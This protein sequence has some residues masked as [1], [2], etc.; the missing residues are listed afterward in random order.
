MT[1]QFVDLNG[2]GQQDMVTATFE[3]TAFLVEGSSEGWKEPQHIKDGKDSNVRISMYYDMEENEYKNVDRSS[4]D[5]KNIEEHHMTSLALVDWDE[6]GDQDLILGA[7]EGALYICMNEGTATEPKFAAT[8]Q[9][10]LANGKHVTMVGGLATPRIVDWNGDG[11]F[12]ILCGGSNGGV[13]W[14]ENIGKGGSPE[15]ASAVALIP[16]GGLSVGDQLPD[17]KDAATDFYSS[18]MVPIKDGLPTRPGSS[19]HIDAVDYDGDGDLDLL[20]GAQSMIKPDAVELS[21]E[22]EKEL[23]QLNKGISEISD[24]IE[25]L[26]EGKSNEEINEVFQGKEASELQKQSGKFYRRRSELQPGPTQMNL[27]WLYRNQSGAADPDT[28]SKS[29]ETDSAGQAASEHAFDTDQFAVHAEFSPERAA[30]GDQVTLT[31]KVN[32]PRGYHIYGAESKTQPTALTLI[33]TGSL[34]VD[35]DALIPTGRLVSDKGSPA[36]WLEG[37]VTIKQTMVVPDDFTETS[38]QGTIDYMMCNEQGCRP[39][40]SEKFTATLRGATK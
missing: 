22:E 19:F 12:D 9:Q 1:P 32:V 31:I 37:V 29:G 20:V 24:K 10:L 36:W 40:A 18:R 23:E 21:E 26:I 16:A 6:D 34:D 8:N 25:K 27:I 5:Y 17:S 35:G 39:P 3:G 28:A 15:F 4:D 14:Y 2:D 7:Y 33:D 30:G 11:L 38:V 13:E